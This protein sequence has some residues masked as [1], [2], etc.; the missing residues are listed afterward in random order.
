M[1][2]ENHEKHE[3]AIYRDEVFAIQGAVFEVSREMGI[4]FLEAVY[5]E[6][7]ALEFTERAIPFTAR[8]NLSLSYKGRALAQAY[9][10]RLRLLR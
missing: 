1:D 10:G 3:T 2:H 4:S 8:R 7:L 9:Q 6:C 5:Q